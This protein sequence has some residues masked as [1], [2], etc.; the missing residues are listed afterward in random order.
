[1]RKNVL[2]YLED[3]A[4]KYSERCAYRDHLSSWTF[5]QVIKTAKAIGSRIGALGQG[6]RPVAVLM[7]KCTKMIVSFLGV[8]YGGCYY[9]PI[10]V[11]MP[12]ERIRTIFAQL[13]PAAVITDQKQLER[14]QELKLSCPVMLFEEICQA[15]ENKQLLEQI[16]KGSVDTDPLYVLF[17]SGSTGIPKGVIASHRLIMNNIEWLESE[18]RF[19]PNDVMGNQAPLHF[20]IANHDIYCPLKFGCSTVIIPYEYFTF[21]VKL[22]PFL[23]KEKVTAIFWVPFALC[24]VANLRALEIEQ[25]DQLRHVFFAGEV[26]P[27]KQLNYWRKYVPNAQYVNMYGSTETHICLY[28][29]LKREFRDDEKL[30]IGQSCGNVD[31][32]VLDEEKQ[33][34]VPESGKTGELYVRGGAVALGYLNDKE[35]TET[36]F[37]QNPLNHHYPERIYRTGDWVSYNEFGELVY[38]ERMDFQI[39][40]LGYRIELGEIEATARGMEEIEEC[41]CSYDT[42]H[43]VIVFFYTGVKLERKEIIK[44]LSKKL[45][46]YMLPGRYVHLEKMIRNDNGKIDRRNLLAW[47]MEVKKEDILYKKK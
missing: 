39:K 36:R 44:Y 23:K 18:Y 7:E 27:V 14:I 15:G 45:P 19:N 35:K 29:Q 26:M 46:K 47:E 28:Y 40:H 1:M 43:Q 33:V 6:R 25:P 5:A 12:L 20:D 37:I 21:P 30:P 11:D 2:E 24:V 10:D 17:T 13:A 38:H 41:A 34:V 22:I 8:V 42:K 16:R 9:C 3:A 31:V 4:K 32:L